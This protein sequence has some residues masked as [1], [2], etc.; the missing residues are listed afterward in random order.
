V[1]LNTYLKRI[2]RVSSTRC[3]ACRAEEET[4]KHFLLDCPNYAHERWAL[5]RQAC[6]LRKRLT[7]ETVLGE[8]SMIGPLASYIN[9]THRF[10]QNGEQTHSAN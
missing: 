8:Q 1:P 9:A 4:I 3:P 6:K 10:A 7:M 2:G 5:T